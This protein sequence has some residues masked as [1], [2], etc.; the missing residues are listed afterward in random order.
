[1][2]ESLDHMLR[3]NAILRRH[4]GLALCARPRCGKCRLRSCAVRRSTRRPPSWADSSSSMPAN[5]SMPETWPG[6]NST[7]RSTS[8][9][10]RAVPFRTD[11]NSDN[12]GYGN[13]GKGPLTPHYR[14]KVLLPSAVRSSIRPRPPA[15]APAPP[16]AA[17]RRSPSAAPG[18][19]APAGA[20]P[21][22]SPAPPPR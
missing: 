12:C 5:V 15:A 13:V 20:V 4:T 16:S 21:A 1:M 11:P 6:S 9:S 22:P 8:L 10:E 14:G 7:R 19:L 3:A 17:P 2:D 18:P